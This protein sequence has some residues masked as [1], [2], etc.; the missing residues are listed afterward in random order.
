MRENYLE[1]CQISHVLGADIGIKELWSGKK[2]SQTFLSSSISA[3]SSFCTFRDFCVGG[4]DGE[5]D[6]RRRADRLVVNVVF[7]VF[8]N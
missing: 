2:K 8:T 5:L 6:L 7:S 1:F 3:G 4:G